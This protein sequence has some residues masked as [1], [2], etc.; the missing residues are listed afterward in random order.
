M[1]SIIQRTRG[2][3]QEVVDEIKKVTWPD[4]PQ[5]KNSTGVVI[6]FVVIVSIIIFLMDAVVRFVLGFIMNLFSGG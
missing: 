3:T 1:A 6:V 4:W 2:F 5:L